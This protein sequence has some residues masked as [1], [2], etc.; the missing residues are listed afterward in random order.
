MPSEKSS[1]TCETISEAGTAGT[2]TD[3]GIKNQ[4]DYN[5]SETIAELLKE[6]IKTQAELEGLKARLGH[7]RY[8]CESDHLIYPKE[9]AYV[10][11]WDLEQEEKE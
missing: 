1:M 9:I 2:V 7:L 4:E 6:L 8:I 11:G 5:M 3:P 10:F